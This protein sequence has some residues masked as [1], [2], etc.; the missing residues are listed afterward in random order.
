MVDAE[1]GQFSSSSTAAH[2]GRSVSLCTVFHDSPTLLQLCGL[3][4]M[5][6]VVVVLVPVNS[7]LVMAATLF[8][9]TDISQFARLFCHFAGGRGAGASQQRRGHGS[10]PP[11]GFRGGMGGFA[12]GGP[13]GY[14]GYGYSEKDGR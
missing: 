1:A 9:P 12:F 3:L 8:N 7:V 14:G 13:P 6:Q 11:P 5:L 4:C 10:G 2:R